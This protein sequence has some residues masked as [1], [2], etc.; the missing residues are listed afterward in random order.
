MSNVD[1]L[2]IEEAVKMILEA[3]GE[4]VNREGLLDTPKRVAKMYAEM[5]SGLHEDAKDYFRTVFHEDHEEL[6]LVKDIPFY[7]MCEHH[8]VPFYGK[9]HVA[10]IPNDG[11]VA[12]LSKLGRAVETI[13]RRPQLQE[14][15]TSA[16]AETIM[17][18]LSPKGVY[19]VIEAEHMCMTMRGLKKPGSKT[20]TSVARGIYEEDEVKRREVL[21]FIQM[22]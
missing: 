13:A 5:F 3:V 14:R 11:I 22:S 2:K 15:I 17:E 9:A 21:S 19:V 20:V 6:V 10:Y 18:M 1:L 12:G 7:S 16:V 8:L 4:D